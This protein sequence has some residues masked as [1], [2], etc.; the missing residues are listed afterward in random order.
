MVPSDAPQV[1]GLASRWLVCNQLG[2]RFL[3]LAFLAGL[4][5]GGVWWAPGFGHL[6]K[7]P[8]VSVFGFGLVWRSVLWCGVVVS[9]CTCGGEC[10]TG[11]P[12]RL[13]EPFSQPKAL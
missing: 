7:S 13:R 2:E 5:W 11:M 9:V 6:H 12:F 3:L 1:L 8:V 10:A 4:G